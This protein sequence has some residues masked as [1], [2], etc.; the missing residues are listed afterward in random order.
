MVY[1]V[2]KTESE[3]EKI[4]LFLF[5]EMMLTARSVTQVSA[6]KVEV[7]SGRRLLLIFFWDS[8]VVS[9]CLDPSIKMDVYVWDHF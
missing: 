6:L 7:P 5:V 3:S 8:P 1:S 9:Q 2:V 4:I